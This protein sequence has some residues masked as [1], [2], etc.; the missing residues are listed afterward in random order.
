MH[1]LPC[2][3]RWM[4]PFVPRSGQAL[5][6]PSLWLITLKYQYQTCRNKRRVSNKSDCVLPP[7]PAVCKCTP[8][9][10]VCPSAQMPSPRKASGRFGTRSAPSSRIPR[11]SSQTCRRTRARARRSETYANA[12]AQPTTPLAAGEGNPHAHTA[13]FSHRPRSS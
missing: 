7:F 11:A 1:G 8:S 12:N 4:S 9:V 10:S 3:E 2:A 13:G 5:P 6:V